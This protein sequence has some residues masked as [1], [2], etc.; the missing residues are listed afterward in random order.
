MGDMDS[1]RDDIRE[2]GRLMRD[3]LKDFKADVKQDLLVMRQSNQEFRN[4]QQ[5]IVVDIA[6]SIGKAGQRA[7]A[8]HVRLDKHEERVESIEDD[9]RLVKRG[10]TVVVSIAAGLAGV[11][12]AWERLVHFI[13]GGY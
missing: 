13:R 7:D 5:S 6:E 1:L 10:G 9:V 8:A 11:I 3:D 12:A 2:V 4:A